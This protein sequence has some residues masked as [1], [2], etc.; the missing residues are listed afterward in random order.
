MHAAHVDMGIYSVQ[1]F[2]FWVL[3]G[4]GAAGDVGEADG[5]GAGAGSPAA[6]GARRARRRDGT[7]AGSVHGELSIS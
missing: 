7:G 1:N 4:W 5:D 6:H 3:A 2:W